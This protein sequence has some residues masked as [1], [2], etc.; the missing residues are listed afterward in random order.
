MALAMASTSSCDGFLLLIRGEI[1]DTGD[2]GDFDVVVAGH[3]H[4]GT[5]LIPTASAPT[6][7][8]ALTSAGVFV[9]GTGPWPCTHRGGWRAGVSP[10]CFPFSRAK[11]GR[12]RLAHVDELDGAIIGHAEQ[13]IDSMKLM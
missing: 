7:A 10:R 6:Q 3:D 2:P 4:L 12:V 1:A 8:K 11:P 9:I 5:V 13:R